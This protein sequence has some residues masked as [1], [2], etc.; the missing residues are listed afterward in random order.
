MFKK[1]IESHKTFFEI[2]LSKKFNFTKHLSLN[3]KNENTL[4]D[5]ISCKKK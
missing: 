1:K 5:K 3:K 2:I 4:S